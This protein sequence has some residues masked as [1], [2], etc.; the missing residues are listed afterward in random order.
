M[1][2]CLRC[3]L[4]FLTSEA[5]LRKFIG[6]NKTVNTLF[7][8]FQTNTDATWKASINNETKI[9]KFTFTIEEND[10]TKKQHYPMHVTIKRL[11]V[12]HFCGG[13]QKTCKKKNH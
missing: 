10:E 13:K 7:S 9:R 3:V 12:I 1:P 11:T 2:Y 8:L 6:S 5:K 4:L